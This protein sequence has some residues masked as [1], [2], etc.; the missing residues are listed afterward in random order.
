MVVEA[1]RAEWFDDPEHG[2]TLRLEGA[3]TLPHL[4]QLE[5]AQRSAAVPPARVDGRALRALDTAGALLLIRRWLGPPPWRMELLLKPAD[6]A[7]LELIAVHDP[8]VRHPRAVGFGLTRLAERVGLGLERLSRDTLLLLAFTGRVVDVLYR[9]LRGRQRL[10]FT[11]AVH[12]MERTGL[13]AVPIVALLCFMVGAVVAFLG[14]TVLSDFGAAVYTVELVAYS[15]LREFGVLLAAIL[16]AGRS[17]SAFTAEIGMM[18]A[19]EEVDA[20][21]ALGLDPIELLVIPRLIALLV[22]LPVLAFIGVLSGFVGGALVGAA[23]L[24]ISPTMFIA[25]L[26][27]ASQL[28]HFGVGMVKAPVFALVIALVG[29]LE[30]FKVRGSAE[31]VG[32]HTTSAVVQAIFLVIL[33]DALFAILFMELDW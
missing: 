12:H 28:S 32:R 1:A 33:L 26:H 2:R 31:S 22:M 3:W 11:A 29:C 27:E 7:L 4:A 24:N 25:R 13:D 5:R 20:I 15:F 19:R 9:I 16:L 6:R 30:G 10:R 23:E 14:A 21:R 8:A 18:R 17:G